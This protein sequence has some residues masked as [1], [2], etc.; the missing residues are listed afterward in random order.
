MLYSFSFYQTN[1]KNIKTPEYFSDNFNYIYQK[2]IAFI[3]KRNSKELEFAL[4]TIN[5]LL[6]RHY[7][8]ADSTLKCN[9]DVKKDFMWCF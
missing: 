8:F 4:Q 1:P 7:Y 9:V 2:A 5:Y 6:S 3:N